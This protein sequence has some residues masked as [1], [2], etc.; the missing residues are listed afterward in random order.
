MGNERMYISKHISK[1]ALNKI[2]EGR[3]LKKLVDE[4]TE[5]T[6]ELILLV[7]WLIKRLILKSNYA[8]R[9][10]ATIDRNSQTDSVTPTSKMWELKKISIEFNLHFFSLESLE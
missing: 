5:Q 2:E 7:S 9:P 3:E 4:G 1:L 8:Q 6:F 10:S